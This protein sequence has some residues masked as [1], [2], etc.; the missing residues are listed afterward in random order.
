M[1]S[2]NVIKSNI[3]GQ[4]KVKTPIANNIPGNTSS[5]DVKKK[6]T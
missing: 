4:G 3:S 2:A 5:Y 1:S 6:K